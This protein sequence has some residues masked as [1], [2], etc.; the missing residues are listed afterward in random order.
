[1]KPA[2]KL[3]FVLFCW[4][5]AVLAPL[6]VQIALLAILV[7]LPLFLPAWTL[8]TERARRTA[9]RFLLF[10]L[11]LGA[12]LVVVNGILFPG[13]AP[14]ITLGRLRLSTPGCQ[15]GLLVALRLALLSGSVLLF[16]LSTPMRVIADFIEERGLP[17]ALALLTMLSVQTVERLPDRVRDILVAQEARGA[18]VRGSL[19]N[20][21]RSLLA[22]LG[23]L[24][25]SS[26]AESIERS[27]AFALR[28]LGTARTLPSYTTAPLS[29]RWTWPLLALSMITVIWR[30]F[31]W[32]MP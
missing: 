20:R 23:P 7:P 21:F 13:G 26:L 19:F 29:S 12:A 22:V 4:V 32:I 8:P 11:T 1:M 31:T 14:A 10:L 30:M 3:A 24:T 9:R 16:F 27:H 18:P 17:P 6:A 15:F 5:T 2:P 25:V 28:G